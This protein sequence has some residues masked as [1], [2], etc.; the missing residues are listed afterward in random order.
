MQRHSVQKKQAYSRGLRNPHVMFQCPCALLFHSQPLRGITW[1]SCVP[2]L[3]IAQASPSLSH[4]AY[5]EWI[6][7]GTQ[8]LKT[9]SSLKLLLAAIGSSCSSDF[10]FHRFVTL[11]LALLRSRLLVY[12]EQHLDLRKFPVRSSSPAGNFQGI[13][14]CFGFK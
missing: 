5:P 7:L 1:L 14:Y 12:K 2:E 9:R 11:F 13:C 8:A 10:H 6:P 4:P 3:R